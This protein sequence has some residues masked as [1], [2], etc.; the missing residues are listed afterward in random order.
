V[1]VFDEGERLR[2]VTQPDHARFAAELVS[3]WREDDLPRHP[4]RD[5]LLFAVR[6]H[7]N[8]WREA[9]AAPSWSSA[10]GRPHDFLSL[11]DAERL[12]V[13]RRGT[14]RYAA[15]RPYAALLVTLHALALFSGRRGDP[16]W[17][18]LLDELG[19]RRD[20]LV[21]AAAVP[22]AEAVAD[23][24][25]LAFA[26]AAALAVATRDEAAFEHRWGDG[27]RRGRFEAA[28]E[29]L[30]LEPFPLAGATTLRLP[31]RWIAKR[32]Y[33]GDAD[34]GGALAE[35]RWGEARVLVSPPRL[36]G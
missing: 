36:P 6:E 33:D 34:L 16:A 19:E 4:R 22:L 9:D 32:L 17:D 27:P 2:L 3:L 28:T 18:P 15:Q 25:H 10:A 13:W 26:D 11:P 7:D 1:I 20:E 35:A 24:R 31:A 21:A 23:F 12:E 5:D 8:G 14:A 30:Y 29:T